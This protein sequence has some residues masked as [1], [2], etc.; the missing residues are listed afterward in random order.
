MDRVLLF[1]ILDALLVTVESN[2]TVPFDFDSVRVAVTVRAPSVLV[3][4]G[5]SVTVRVRYSRVS[6]CSLKVTVRV[7]RVTSESLRVSSFDNVAV[8]VTF[9]VSRLSESVIVALDSSCEFERERVPVGSFPL[10]LVD[11][12]LV[13]EFEG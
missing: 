12:E 3:S 2:V 4:V 10:T 11:K 6:E 9:G 5:L 8:E 1:A 13:R 7:A